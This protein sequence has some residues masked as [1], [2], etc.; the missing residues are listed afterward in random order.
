MS[1]TAAVVRELVAAGLSGEALVTACER[2]QTDDYR[3][4][5]P[6]AERRRAYDRNRKRAKTNNNSIGIPPESTG[7]PSLDKETPPDPQKKLNPSPKENPLRGQKK[8]AE[9]FPDGF[10][11]DWDFALRLGFSRKQ[12]ET[13]LAKLRDWSLSSEHGAKL[14][15]D[16]AWRNWM[17]NATPRATSPPVSRSPVVV[18]ASQILSER[19]DES[20]FDSSNHPD[21]KFLPPRSD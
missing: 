17:R 3:V 13:E 20:K 9:R 11:P 6:V 12:A 16:A 7:T 18:A 21:V 2:I 1:L 10:E 19:Q 5:D 14:D 4:Q 15:W 8:R